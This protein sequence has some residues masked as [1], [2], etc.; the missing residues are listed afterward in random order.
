MTPFF[1][2]LPHEVIINI[3]EFSS[4]RPI[5]KIQSEIIR[6]GFLSSYKH[7]QDY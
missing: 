3:Y 1:N 6:K 5:K 7:L 2:K 4:E